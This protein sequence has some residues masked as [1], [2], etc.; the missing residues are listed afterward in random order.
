[1]K[2]IILFTALLFF[3]LNAFSQEKIEEGIATFEFNYP[4]AESVSPQTLANFGT[5]LTVYFKKGL[6]REEYDNTG[7]WVNIVDPKK[8][9][10]LAMGTPAQ[11]IATKMTFKE[12]A[13]NQAMAFRKY[14]VRV[15]DEVK[16]IVGLKCRKAKVIYNDDQTMEVWYTSQLNAC[17]T[18]Y[19]FNGINGFIMQ[20][21]HVMTLYPDIKFTV[22]MICKKVEKTKVPDKLFKLPVNCK[23]VT[24]Q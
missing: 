10:I 6:S 16:D 9:E 4:D 12:K 1:M 13:D 23:L 3:H 8:K 7:R 20:Y 5:G 2:I 17:N 21:S 14:S 22:E 19:F 15:T 18:Q 11:D 24:F